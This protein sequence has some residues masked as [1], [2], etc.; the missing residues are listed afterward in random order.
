VLRGLDD[1][2]L[3]RPTAYPDLETLNPDR[4]LSEAREVARGRE[5]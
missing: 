2:P 1:R 4:R 5:P 3:V